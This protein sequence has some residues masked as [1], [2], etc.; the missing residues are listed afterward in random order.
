MPHLRG[1]F[2]FR[3]LHRD[4]PLCSSCRM[5]HVGPAYAYEWGSPVF[6]TFIRQGSAARSGDISSPERLGDSCG[7]LGPPSWW[8]GRG[9]DRAHVRRSKEK[10]RRRKRQ[11]TGR[12]LSF[13]AE[14]VKRRCVLAMPALCLGLASLLSVTRSRGEDEVGEVAGAEAGVG[15]AGEAAV[16]RLVQHLNACELVCKRKGLLYPRSREVLP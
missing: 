7:R 2:D 3:V 1:L 9:Q 11:S 10:G 4:V 14:P 15:D 16:E 6:S 12:T 13:P 5:S 8:F